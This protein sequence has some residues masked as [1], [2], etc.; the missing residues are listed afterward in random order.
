MAEI[1]VERS[2]EDTFRVEIRQG[3]KPSVHQV[4]AT[5]EQL[6]R[7]GGGDDPEGLIRA[8]FRFLLERE[9]AESILSRFELPVIERYFPEYPQE[10]RK[11]RGA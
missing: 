1:D 6:E 3:G 8:S 4:T 11:K 7:Y 10:I 5:A 2:G 9:P